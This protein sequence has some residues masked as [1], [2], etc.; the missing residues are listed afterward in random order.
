MSGYSEEEASLV[1]VEALGA[2]HQPLAFRAS[3]GAWR[4]LLLHLRLDARRLV[5]LHANNLKNAYVDGYAPTEVRLPTSL[6]LGSTRSENGKWTS[7]SAYS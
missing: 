5:A 3:R 1:A 7:R 6:E 2:V 4:A